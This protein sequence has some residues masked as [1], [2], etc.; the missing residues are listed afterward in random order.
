MKTPLGRLESVELR[1]YW[2][3]EARD[4][5][6]WLA[7]DDNINLLGETVGMELEVQ[8]KE[9]KVGTFSADILCKDINTDRCVIIENQLEKTDHD[10]L[11]KVITYCSGLDAYTAIWIAKT[12]DEEHRAAI[13]WLNSIT[14]DNYN[15]FG[16]E[17]RLFKI[18]DSALAPQFDIV[19]KPNNWSKQVKKQASGNNTETENLRLEY[20]QAFHDFVDK[21]DL[22]VLK[23]GKA[24]TD[25][26]CEFR[27]GIS[28]FHYDA[29]ITIKN[30]V[31]IQLYLTGDNIPKTKARY[32]LIEEKCKG[33]IE[34][35]KCKKVEWKR[36]DDKKASYINMKFEA[37]IREKA[38]WYRQFEW[39]YNTMMELHRIMKPHYGEIRGI[40]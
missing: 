13:D 40:K 32:D 26:W 21:K 9:A 38:D 17:V 14:D 24:T 20:W 10:H 37:D 7:E 31:G 36:L 8:E 39:M 19:A 23:H 35:L 4:F 29:V 33:E 3:D 15:F 30:W 5:T 12:F 25:H 11:G 2:K 18:G 22:D 16:I 27:L 1:D 34:A 6:P 28:G